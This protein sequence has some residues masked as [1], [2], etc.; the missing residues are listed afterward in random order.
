MVEGCEKGAICEGELLRLGCGWRPVKG[1]EEVVSC[2]EAETPL[3]ARGDEDGGDGSV[4]VRLKE[5]K[6]KGKQ[7]HWAASFG[8]FLAEGKGRSIEMAKRGE[9]RGSVGCS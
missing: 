6:A 4:V 8:L 1:D 5:E 2:V 7:K 3:L 9:D